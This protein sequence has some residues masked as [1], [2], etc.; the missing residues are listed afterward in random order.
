MPQL[1]TFQNLGATPAPRVG[2]G[3]AGLN[4]SVGDTGQQAASASIGLG[5]AVT[6]MGDAIEVIAANEKQ[7]LD[8][9]GLSDSSA[10]YQNGLLDMEW[11]DNG[12][13]KIL[14]GD[15]VKQPIIQQYQDKRKELAQTI[16]DSLPNSTQQMGFDKRVAIMDQQFNA[17]IYRHVADQ[18]RSYQDA[19]SG[20]FL[21][22]ERQAAALNWKQPGQ[23]EMSLLRTNKEIERQAALKGVDDP[24]IINQMKLDASTKLHAN[25]MD[26][27]L[28]GGYD[29]P[30]MTYY[31]VVKDQ[32]T[33]EAQVILGGKVKVANTEGEAIRGTDVIWNAAGPKGPNDPGRMD[34][35]DSMVRDMFKD[36]PQQMK[37]AEQDLHA[38]FAA[39]NE[40]QAEFTAS[41]QSKVLE[42]YHNGTTLADLQTM[43][44]FQNLDG[45]TKDKLRNYIIERGYTDQQHARMDVQYDEAEKSKQGFSTYWVLSNPKV[46]NTMSESQILSQ[47]PVI[48]QK[49]TQ[50]LM[51]KKRTLD[52]PTS[53]K[54]AT[55]EADLFNTE[56]ANAGYKPY[57]KNIPPDQKEQLGRIRNEVEANIDI[58]QR[59]QGKELN[60]EEKQKIMQSV[61]DQKVMLDKWSGDKSLPAAVIKP[62]QRAN[63][64]VPIE[65]IDPT[66][67]KGAI[68]FMRS[69]GYAPIDWS[70][71]KI[72]QG[73]Q[74]RLEHGYAIS[75]TGGTGEEGRKALSGGK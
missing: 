22:S 20:A 72:K 56:V 12:F 64:Y 7:K 27:M 30:A 5:K 17:Q 18:T 44:E 47:E 19:A 71:D 1:P 48:G 61:V 15:A 43:P 4:L 21:D 25:V 2:G 49:L 39:H 16:R 67:L 33:P 14:N 9:A 69:S 13:T 75:V 36:D 31:N 38:R 8:E 40:G 65:Q 73:M 26:Q 51:T 58:A 54:A 34:I 23:I 74:K 52:S 63:V 55:I 6:S 29:A 68:N 28:V 45:T 41:N 50:E 57:D 70:D 59:T 62:E 11:G 46:L 32:L 60:R 3:V 24:N 53:V 42:A 35:M 37:A 10:K 66:W